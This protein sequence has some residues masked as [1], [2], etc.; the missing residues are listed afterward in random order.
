MQYN[1]IVLAQQGVP[2]GCFA[3]QI[4]LFDGSLCSAL[5]QLNAKPLRHAARRHLSF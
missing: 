1:M 3:R 5:P 2:V 4:A